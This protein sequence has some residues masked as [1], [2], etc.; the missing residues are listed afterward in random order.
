[1]R[2]ESRKAISRRSGPSAL[3]WL[4][5]LLAACA[6]APTVRPG[7]VVAAP[8]APARAPAA[9]A[10]EVAES[11]ETPS[12][13]ELS[14]LSRE[15][16]EKEEKRLAAEKAVREADELR[17]KAL[18]AK[19][20]PFF[21][22]AFAA[23]KEGDETRA[24]AAY[25]RA[26]A[27][28]PEAFAAHLNLG[29]LLERRGRPDEAKAAYEKA[30]TLRPEYA[31]ASENL[32]R[33]L[34]RVGRAD[35]AEAGLK[36]RIRHA[37]RS[38]PLRNQYVRVLLARGR[39]DEAETE[40]KRILK[41]EERNIDAML[42]LATLWY[43][44]KKYEL[45]RTVLDNA[46][47]IDPNEPAVWNLLA[48]CQ[49]ALEQRPLALE[50]LRKASEL[51]EDFPEAHNNYGALLAETN[52][53]DGA[54][55]ELELAARYAPEAADVRVNL[56]NA[57]RCARR[58]TDARTQ[59]ER[60]LALDAKLSDPWFDLAILQLDGEVPGT[61]GKVPEK[62]DRL[63]AS[64][65][66]FERYRQ[67]GGDDPRLGRY[68]DEA[69]KGV[70]REEARLTRVAESKRRSD[71]KAKKEAEKQRLADEKAKAEAAK[72][73][74]AFE[75]KKVAHRGEIEDDGFFA[76]ARKE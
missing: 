58:F 68:A 34:L 27:D 18:E 37:P 1:M 60:A 55:R 31:E 5:L 42:H 61:D 53:C 64:L 9:P 15:D 71:E 54:I 52:D 3:A 21:D 57:Y 62:L 65:A 74:A 72:R 63:K 48:F 56:G 67:A 12:L 22:E 25:R 16:R 32:V 20:G 23:L 66:A 8:A 29:V 50:S 69:K 39:D 19:I 49:L 44:Q 43:G 51:R 28:A 45:A 26:I 46:R 40:A 75:A 14:R 59:Y 76:P 7:P 70:E 2:R 24:E 33:L 35:E 36:L 10:E 41:V 4:P 73:R 13:E 11:D 6:T 47:Q 38:I 30:L 17:L